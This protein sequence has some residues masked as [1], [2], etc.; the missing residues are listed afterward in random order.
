MH[1]KYTSLKIYINLRDRFLK[2]QNKKKAVVLRDE[3]KKSI[4]IINNLLHVKENVLLMCPIT[5]KRYIECKKTEN[6][7]MFII[8]DREI[9]SIIKNGFYSELIIPSYYA[10]QLLAEFDK[11]INRRRRHL[12]FIKRQNINNRLDEIILETN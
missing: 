6:L 10:E 12:E 3:Q 1:L 7:D 8:L 2:W 9:T 4:T 5:G 11:E